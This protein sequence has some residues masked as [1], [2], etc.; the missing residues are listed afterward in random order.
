MAAA[1]GQLEVV[2]FLIQVKVRINPTDRWGAT[3]LNDAKT[4]AMQDLL[5]K[6]GGVKGVE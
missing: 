2:K 3:P 1:S 4:K 5:I 6:H